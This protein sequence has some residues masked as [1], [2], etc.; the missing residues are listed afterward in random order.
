MA[1]TVL[2]PWLNEKHEET[3]AVEDDEILSKSCF[4]I[5]HQIDVE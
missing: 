2:L 1:P 5:A 3:E 4:F